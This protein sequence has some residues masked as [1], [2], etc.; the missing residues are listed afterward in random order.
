[1]LET[2]LKITKQRRQAKR[3]APMKLNGL[4]EIYRFFSENKTPI[5]FIS[6][7]P[8]NILGLGQLV[9]SLQYINY[10]DCF[11]R[12]HHR[13]FTPEERESPEFESMVDVVNYLLRQKEVIKLIRSQPA[14]GK[15]LTVMFDEE[16]EVLAKKLGLEIALPPAEL[17]NRIDSK[18]VTTQ[19]ANEAGVASVPNVLGKADDYA[20]LRAL[21]DKAGLG[22]S[23]VVQTPYGDSGRTTFFINSESDWEEYAED[24]IGE[25]I[26][27]MKRIDP[28]SGTV[29]GVATRHGTLVGPVMM[30]VVGHTEITP[31]KGGW[32]GNE[33]AATEFSETQRDEIIQMM[34]SLGD[35]LYQ[36]GYKGTFCMDFLIDR[37]TQAVYLG[38]INPRISGASPVTNLITQKYGGVPLLFFHLLEFFDVDYELDL[39]AIQQ[40]WLHY[41]S[42]STLVLKQ[43]HEEVGLITSAPASG[44]WRLN[45]G[46]GIDFLRRSV[47]WSNASDQAEGFFLR[48]LGEGEYSYKG[49]DLG[50]LLTRG[51]VQD[52]NGNINDRARNW[53]SAIKQQYRTTLPSADMEPRRYS[54]LHYKIY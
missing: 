23:L 51:R 36:E 17:R 27:V 14:G 35:R 5:Y 24:I 6:A 49:A 1:V 50:I 46:G 44:I 21:A 4:N 38:E 37:D 45:D 2:I 15:L 30:E 9:P 7:S 39:E 11:D 13:V 29:E 41:D 40:R 12:F 26:K 10:F 34:K 28:I 53:N 33:T 16:T 25:E 20:K 18:I 3:A 54:G 31:Y 43:T 22:D 32:C 42:W 19:L 47:D 48:I 8:F 52:P